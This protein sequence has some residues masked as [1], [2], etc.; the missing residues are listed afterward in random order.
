MHFRAAFTL[1]EL[2]VVVSIIA[3]LAALLLPAVAL[4]REKSRTTVCL[5]N[6]RQTAMAVEAYTSD[7]DGILPRI[8]QIGSGGP[9]NQRHWFE[10][11]LPYLNVRAD[12]DVL[13]TQ[14]A[15][16][17]VK[18]CP[19]WRSP[20]ENWR[21]GYG[22]NGW[23]ELPDPTAMWNRWNSPTNGRDLHVDRITHPSQR[24]LLGDSSDW[25]LTI[26]MP[27]WVQSW[28]PERHRDR[29]VY[30]FCDLHVATLR[31][32]Q[33]VLGLTDPARLNP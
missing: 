5:S 30:A 4:A 14:V 3:V 19:A 25:H 1:I 9:G 11:I 8:K 6:L 32:E 22:M 20:G 21:Q 13:A 12:R 28:D 18:G 29:A 15:R 23:L 33:T 7:H 16:S 27:G 26:H 10:F 24:I 31:R 17:V 2:L